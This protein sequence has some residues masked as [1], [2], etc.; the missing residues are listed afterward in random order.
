MMPLRITIVGER[1]GWHVTQLVDA[2]C[3]RRHAA[4]VVSWTAVGAAIGPGGP[5]FSPE[6]LAAA[7]VVVVRGMPGVGPTASRLEDVIFRMDALAQLEAGGTP[8]VNRPRALEIAIDKYLSLAVLA[9]AGL[10]VPRTRVVQG[11]AMAREAWE[12]LGGDCV[13]KPLFG[14]R[15]RGLVRL[16]DRDEAAAAGRGGTVYLQEFIRHPGWDIRVLVIGDDAF[17]MRRVAAAGEWRTNISLGGQPEAIDLPA[18]TLDLARRAADAVGATVAGVDLLPT[19]DGPV[20]LE[21][22]AVP[23]WRGLQS[24][25]ATDLADALAST[26]ERASRRRPP[27]A[28]P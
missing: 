1:G 11:E 19:A 13:A 21:V 6:P 20:V 28:T 17:A 22:N 15:G 8:V 16:R 3:N 26:V 7:D 9:R 14:S 18:A 2:L 10:T 25:V 27:S 4:E 23:A 24:V 5:A 12:S